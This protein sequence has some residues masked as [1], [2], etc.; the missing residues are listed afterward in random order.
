MMNLTH[1]FLRF[2]EGRERALTLS[3][4]DG[5]QQ[6]MRLVALL[7]RHGIKATFNLNSGLLA[8]NGTVYPAGQIQ[9]RM[10]EAEVMATYSGTSHEIAA[11]ALTHSFLEQLPPN[12]ATLEVLEDRTALEN[13]FDTIVRGMAYPYGTLN[14]SVVAALRACGI[15]YCR[16]TV[17]S[18]S[19]DEP[20]DWLR[21]QPTCHHADPLLMDL[22]QHFL[23]DTITRRPY[24]FYVW[25]HSYEFER[26]DNWNV[27]EQFCEAAGGREEVWYA[28]NIELYD[29]IAAFHALQFSNS[30]RI[31]FNPTCRK[32]WFYFRGET[33]AIAAGETLRI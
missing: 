7:N 13:R 28:T 8:P 15:A 6:D 25:G 24:L 31:I 12:L 20:I 11:H 5:V 14:D 16:T 30:G 17:S 33:Y 23:T 32:V 18:H 27:I 21:L 19:F 22:T 9:R 26:D 3:Y 4:D 29:Y 1:L 10:T 2:P